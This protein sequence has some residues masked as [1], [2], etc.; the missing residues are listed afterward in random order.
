[1]VKFAALRS[2]KFDAKFNLSC[3]K[4]GFISEQK[5]GQISAINLTLPLNLP[6]GRQNSAAS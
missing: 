2:F 6:H 4:F 5:G 3:V 1:M